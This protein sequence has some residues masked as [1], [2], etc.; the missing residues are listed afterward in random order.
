LLS[1]A[2][3]GRLLTAAPY[4][5]M[6]AVIVFGVSAGLYVAVYVW[7]MGHSWLIRAAA[8]F[9]TGFV[10]TAIVLVLFAPAYLAVRAL[11]MSWTI[12]WLCP[13]LTQVHTAIWR[14]FGWFGER[15][16]DALKRIIDRLRP[17]LVRIGRALAVVRDAYEQI[18]RTIRGTR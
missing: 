10:A 9:T 16:A 17:V 6:S 15:V 1:Y 18:L 12:P 7:A 14:P 13:L 4:R 11:T 3:L 2:G 5:L 8:L